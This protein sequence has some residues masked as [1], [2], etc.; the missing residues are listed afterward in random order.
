MNTTF[1]QKHLQTARVLTQLLENRF[2][3]GPFKFGLDPIIG[4]VPVVGDLIPAILSGYLIWIGWK[5]QIPNQVLARMAVNVVLDYAVGLV[6]VLGDAVDFV[7]KSNTRNL[8]ILNSYA[9]LNP[10]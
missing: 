3:I 7:F 4:L 2:K 5:M 8:S 10:A 1:N 6:P 9:N